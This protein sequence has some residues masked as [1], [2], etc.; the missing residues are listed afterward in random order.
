MKLKNSEKKGTFN[1]RC[2]RTACQIPVNVN[3]YNYSTQKWYCPECAELINENC[4]E[5]HEVYGHDLLIEHEECHSCGGSGES[6]H[7]GGHCCICNGFGYLPIGD[8]I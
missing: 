3:W 7:N 1:G 8:K 6:Q 4:P 2:N 5:A